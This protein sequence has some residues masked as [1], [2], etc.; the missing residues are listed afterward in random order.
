MTPHSWTSEPAGSITRHEVQNAVA[1]QL[2]EHNNTE[3]PERLTDAVLAHRELVPLPTPNSAE[4]GWEQLW[5]TRR[6]LALEAE[7][8]QLFQPEPDP[9]KALDPIFVDT[10]LA[11]L[12]RPLGTDQADT[13]RRVCTQGLGVEVV[14]GRAGSGKTY[15]MRTVREI[16]QTAGQR[17]VGVCP[18]A[19]AARELADGAGIKS[20]TIPRT[21]AA[22]RC[23]REPSR[24]PGTSNAVWTM[25]RRGRAR[26]EQLAR[27][28]WTPLHAYVARR[29]PH[30]D[31]DDIVSETLTTLWR[32]FDDVP[33]DA[34]LPWSLAV[35]RRT[36]AN[37]RRG[38]RRR[39]GL[40][41]R[42][43]H[44][45]RPADLATIAVPEFVDDDPQ[46]VQALAQLPTDDVELVRLWAWEHL[47]PREIAVVL[48][49]S[50]NTASARLSRLRRRLHD[51]LDARHDRVG[52]GHEPGADQAA[53]TR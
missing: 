3:L 32:R 37:Q 31:V 14:V 41:D 52:A 45:T 12:N 20:F 5:T 22:S 8:T 46:L 21:L 25:M 47:E 30:S 53:S 27:E 28:V 34:T 35:A 11:A 50:A 48:G 16:Y 51:L 2:S 42:A 44:R 26:F 23:E 9:N 18:T 1:E 24:R 7:L 19:R 4:A 6:L 13:V 33:G 15:T 43:V 39:A 38:D 49:I 40:F 29:A 17:L 10:T 36:L